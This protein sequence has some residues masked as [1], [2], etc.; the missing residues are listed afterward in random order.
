MNIRE[1][2]EK[3]WN[4]VKNDK[5]WLKE[6]I[7][8]NGFEI[9]ER[10]KELFGKTASLEDI[11]K[12]YPHAP[13]IA[14]NR[15]DFRHNCAQIILENLNDLNKL[16]G[17]DYTTSKEDISK[18]IKVGYWEGLIGEIKDPHWFYTV[19]LSSTA[20]GTYHN[21]RT[22][23]IVFHTKKSDLFNSKKERMDAIPHEM[24]HKILNE[25]QSTVTLVPITAEGICIYSTNV[26]DG[27]YGAKVDLDTTIT[28]FN[29]LDY[30]FSLARGE[31]RTRVISRAFGYFK[32]FPQLTESAKIN[33]K[34][35]G[36]GY[37]SILYAVDNM[38]EGIIREFVNR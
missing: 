25:S 1:F 27:K 36:I 19:F 24:C 6:A 5:H 31:E 14:R 30:G 12:G 11:I 20:N 15:K 28:C 17:T 26:M 33:R 2:M 21:P 23:N 16:L 7:A 4:D 18:F 8:E 22:G 29:C 10:Y 32:P 13:I 34:I 37:S 9:L 35:H 38:G 3:S